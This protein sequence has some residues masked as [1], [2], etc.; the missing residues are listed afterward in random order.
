MLFASARDLYESAMRGNTRLALHKRR[1]YESYLV[2]VASQDFPRHAG[3]VIAVNN[4]MV[5]ALPSVGAPM[6]AVQISQLREATVGSLG[7]LLNTS[8]I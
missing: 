2:V 4:A 5:R 3:T 1:R 8:Q 7:F 6:D